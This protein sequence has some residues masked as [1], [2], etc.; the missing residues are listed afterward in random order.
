MVSACGATEPARALTWGSDQASVTIANGKASIQVVASGGCYGAYGAFDHAAPLDTFARPGTYTQLMG[1]YPGS[2][3]YTA[4]YDGTVV[5]DAMTL[6]ISVPALGHTI[7]PFQLT[8]G[9]LSAWSACLY[10]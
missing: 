2:V 5:G 3:Q 9:V 4:E 6:S 7:G 8:A 1:A 10:P